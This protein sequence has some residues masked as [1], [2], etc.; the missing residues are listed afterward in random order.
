MKIRDITIIIAIIAAVLAI[1]GWGLTNVSME[2]TRITGIDSIST[3]SFT[4]SG[5]LVMNNPAL[6]SVNVESADYDLVLRSNGEVIGEGTIDGWTLEPGT[7]ETSFTHQTNWRPTAGMA[8]ELLTKDQV[9]VDMKGNATVSKFGFSYTLPFEEEFDIK[10]Y[11]N[12]FVPEGASDTAR[13]V[14]EGIRRA[15]GN[16]TGLADVVNGLTS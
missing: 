13:Q 11:V 10:A 6:I 9:Y 3:D 12:Q 1:L 14:D 4:L 7:S 16:S 2:E 15:T 5:E 8:A